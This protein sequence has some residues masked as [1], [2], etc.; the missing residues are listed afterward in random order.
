MKKLLFL[1]ITLIFLAVS[2]SG[3]KKAEND[4][5]T[6]I[7][8]DEDAVEVIEKEDF[9]YT[10][11]NEDNPEEDV[12]NDEDID[13]DGLS[14]NDSVENEN[15]VVDNSTG[16]EWQQ[17]FV[18]ITENYYQCHKVETYCENLNYGGHDDWRVPSINELFSIVD[19][20]KYD[21]ATDT[22]YFADI[23]S[24]DFLSSS[25]T[26]EI[27]FNDRDNPLLYDR[28]SCCLG[29]NFYDG[30][31]IFCP[32]DENSAVKNSYVR[33]VRGES[34][35]SESSAK[36]SAVETHGK[37]VTIINPEDN[38]LWQSQPVSN[39]TWKQALKYCDELNLSELLNWRLPDKKEL[40]AAFPPCEEYM[41]GF[42]IRPDYYQTFYS[43]YYWSSSSYSADSENAWVVNYGENNAESCDGEA[44]LD[45]YWNKAKASS[46][47]YTRCVTENPCSK[48][49]VWNGE[50]CIANKCDPNPCKQMPLER[51]WKCVIT[52]E[53]EAGYYCKCKYGWDRENLTCLLS[54]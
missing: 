40:L 20:N 18:E 51:D 6:D 7:L 25:I 35:V 4:I 23:P 53:E 10:S 52:A 11:D 50:T 28:K 46:D 3:S 30:S 42:Y 5:D 27:L 26:S 2:C 47:V 54:D 14:V 36:L 43:K 16:L 17:G 22:S 37:S 9:D 44:H 29:V 32:T 49:E 13:I 41:P 19:L 12:K 31:T 39:Q 38:L 1:L 48:G 34:L 21:P 45:A 33:C 15:T 24:E 8:P